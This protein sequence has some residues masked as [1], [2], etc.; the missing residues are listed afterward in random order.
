MAARAPLLLV[1][2]VLLAWAR[3]PLSGGAAY[4]DREALASPVV[5]GELPALEAFR[6]DYWHHLGD[7]GHYRPVA[8]L[9]LRLDHLLWGGAWRGYHLTNVLLHLGVVLGAWLLARRLGLPRREA[10][11]GAAAFGLHPALADSVA[12][13]SGRTSMLSALGGL[14]ALL[15]ASA[16]PAPRSRAGPSR[17]RASARGEQARLL[18]VGAGVAAG[19]LLGL[20]GKEDALV[21]AP[22][23]VL[24]AW[25]RG[26]RRAALAAAAGA[27]LALLAAGSLRAGALGSPWPEAP[28]APL[29]GLPLQERLAFGGRALGEAAR[30]A[31]LPLGPSPS[32]RHVAGFHPGAPPPATWL[33]AWAPFLLALV[34]GAAWLARVTGAER[35]AREGSAVRAAALLLAPASLLPVLQIVPAG[36]VF[37]PRFLYLPLLLGVPLWGALLARLVRALPWAGAVLAALVIGLAWRGSAPYLGLGRWAEAVLARAPHD[38]GAWNTLGLA[39][40]ERGEPEA[41]RE[42][43]RRATEI[44]PGYGRAW[45]NLG[46]LLAAEG[47]L[48]AAEDALRRA[49]AGGP[50]NPIARCN[51]AAL[52]LRRDGAAEAL[53]LYRSACALAPGLA[54]AW[55][56]RANAA[57]RL[58]LE[59]EARSARARA[60]ALDPGGG[61]T[62]VVEGG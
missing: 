19:L 22:A 42:A 25:W 2:L 54:P 49:V 43:W 51:L 33:L 35:A 50:A 57:G 24:V 8:T 48:A 21:L 38:V 4:D 12:W 47:D 15:A 29:A 28:Q 20:L 40:E 36:E 26:G 10:L 11:L 23:A 56:G 39:R 17:A 7:A 34:V 53:E 62:P 60:A 5:R 58:G 46:R 32:Y 14:G 6:R 61:A 13:I 3:A 41:A 59:Q 52:L 9:S 44:D 1:L 16:A 27:G 55:R 30:L 45:S 37:A 18:G 31:L